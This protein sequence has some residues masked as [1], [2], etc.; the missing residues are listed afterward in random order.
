MSVRPAVEI[1]RCVRPWHEECL[2][3]KTNVGVA[4]RPGALFNHVAWCEVWGHWIARRKTGLRPSYERGWVRTTS[5]CL[6]GLAP[7]GR[8]EWCVAWMMWR[9]S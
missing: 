8:W 2:D 4:L 3:R 5:Y 1:R 9:P 6:L 7:D